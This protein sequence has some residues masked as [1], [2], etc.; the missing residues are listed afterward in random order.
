[1]INIKEVS[2]KIK[3]NEGYSNKI[4]YDKL[5]NSTIGYGHLVKKNEK[6]TENKKYLKKELNDLF[7]KDLSKAIKDYNEL[8]IK[9]NLPKHISEVLVEMIF[10]LGSKNFLTFKKMIKAIK[11]KNF[12]SASKEMKKSLWYK[13]TPIRVLKLSKIMSREND[14]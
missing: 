5:G 2:E 1:L 13:Q 11:N 8:F 9:E 12:I 7:K 3:K 10:Q 6:F 4:Y 14:R